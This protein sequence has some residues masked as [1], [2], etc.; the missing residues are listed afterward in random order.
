MLPMIRRQAHYAFRSLPRGSREEAIQ[1]VIAQAFSLFHRLCQRGRAE[2]A[3][4]SALARYAIHQYREG[5]RC[6]TSQSSRDVM[7]VKAKR[8][9]GLE[10]YSLAAP[11]DQQGT[12]L[13]CLIDSR[14]A[15]IPERVALRIDFAEWL[16]SQTVRNR[17]IVQQLSLGYTTKEVANRFQISPGRVSQL[18][19]RFCESW[20]QFC[21]DGPAGCK[22]ASRS[23]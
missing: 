8:K 15:S 23:P 10:F 22:V 14:V 19:R 1:E 2:L 11:G 3:Y 7:S 16:A 9:M 12:W 4:G 20:R 17:Q 21:H 6:G 5:R 18:R 13:E